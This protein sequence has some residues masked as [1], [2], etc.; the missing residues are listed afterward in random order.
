MKRKN[1]IEPTKLNVIAKQIMQKNKSEKTG[2]YSFKFLI[3]GCIFLV[4]V[5]NLLNFATI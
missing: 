5:Y 3:Y 4:F 1:R 2:L